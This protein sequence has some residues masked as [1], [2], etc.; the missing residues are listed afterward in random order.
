MMPLG[1][2]LLSIRDMSTPAF[3]SHIK[4]TSAVQK[5]TFSSTWWS[6]SVKLIYSSVYP[7][8]FLLLKILLLNVHIKFLRKHKHGEIY[9][10]RDYMEDPLFDHVEVKTG[11][12][13]ECEYVSAP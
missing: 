5:K 6:F 4:P 7:V 13:N 11:K 2:K 8:I 9:V 10:V 12:A 3:Y 1:W